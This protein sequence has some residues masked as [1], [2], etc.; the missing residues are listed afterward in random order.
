[1]GRHPEK[2]CSPTMMTSMPKS[3]SS[4]RKLSDMPSKPCLE[5]AYAPMKGAAN[6]PPIDE[7]MMM[8]PGGPVSVRSAPSSGRNACRQER[9]LPDVD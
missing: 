4:R 7:T 3:I 9:L 2:E 5:A 8:R 1:M 6:L